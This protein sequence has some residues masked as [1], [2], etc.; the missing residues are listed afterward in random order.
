LQI[1]LRQESVGI[2]GIS[3]VHGTKIKVSNIHYELSEDELIV[4]LPDPVVDTIRLG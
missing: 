2:D 4:P 1:R 3:V